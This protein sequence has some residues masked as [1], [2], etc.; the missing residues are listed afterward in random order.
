MLTTFRLMLSYANTRTLRNIDSLHLP[1]II[2][3]GITP[4]LCKVSRYIRC[5]VRVAVPGLSSNLCFLCEVVSTAHI[6]KTK[7]ALLR[8]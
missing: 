5:Q 1:K 7:L 2:L 4:F 6:L 3:A 8:G